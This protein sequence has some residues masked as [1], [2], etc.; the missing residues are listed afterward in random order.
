MAN[1]SAVLEKRGCKY[2]IRVYDKSLSDALGVP[3][4]KFFNSIKSGVVKGDE[5]GRFTL[6]PY[7]TSFFTLRNF[8][9][10]VTV[11]K[12]V[13]IVDSSGRYMKVKRKMSDADLI[14]AL[15]GVIIGA[16]IFAACLVATG[17]CLATLA[18]G[19]VVL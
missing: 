10:T 1:I 12:G 7:S 15:V 16:I 13:I 5:E 6:F 17:G 19:G 9:Q 11:K 8:D 14:G 18:A 2:C 3:I 4:W